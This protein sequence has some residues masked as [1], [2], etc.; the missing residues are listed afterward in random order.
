MVGMQGWSALGEALA[1]RIGQPGAYEEGQMTGH[2][3]ELA[4]QQARRERANAMIDTVRADNYQQ[5]PTM[6]EELGITPAQARLIAAGGGNAAQLMGALGDARG[7]GYQ[8]QAAE[9]AAR[10]Y[11]PDNPNAPLFGLAEGPVA[12]G[13]IKDGMAIGDRFADGGGGLTV[14][15]LGEATIRQRNASAASS[16]ATANNANVR[17]AIARGQY[18]AQRAGTWDPSGAGTGTAGPRG[19]RAPSG[20]RWTAD[21]TLQAI[22][23]GPADKGGGGNDAN[24]NLNPRQQ[25]AVQGVQRNLVQYAAALLGKD[26]AE[27][28]RLSAAEIADQIERN[29]RRTVQGGAARLLSRLPGG[30]TLGEL[31]NVDILS[32]SQGAGAAWAAFENPTGMITNADRET[33]TAQMPTYLDPPEV[34]ARKI[35]SFLELSG[36]RPQGGALGD[37]PAPPPSRPVAPSGGAPARITSQAQFNAL[38]SGTVFIAPDGS[39]RRKP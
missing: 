6:G 36:Y 29:G 10:R 11:G 37:A 16:Y 34:Q 30:T 5:L 21:G 13:D 12:L 32:Y 22:P 31:N 25:V 26:P 1:G 8:Q 24:S 4:M 35:R 3:L 17:S 2:K 23:G 20:Y 27:I 28:S 7:M 19:M 14:T 9:A 33:A 15:P 39:Q 18:E 38:P